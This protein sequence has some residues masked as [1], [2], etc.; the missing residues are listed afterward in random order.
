MVDATN[1]FMGDFKQGQTG[2]SIMSQWM[3]S[4]TLNDHQSTAKLASLFHSSAPFPSVDCFGVNFRAFQGKRLFSCSELSQINRVLC[5]HDHIYT[6]D[7]GIGSYA[8][9]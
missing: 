9:K 7:M 8:G 4:P 5:G 3:P 2:K 1:F 6:P